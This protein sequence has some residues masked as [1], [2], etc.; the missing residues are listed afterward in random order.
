TG[1]TPVAHCQDAEEGSD[2]SCECQSPTGDPSCSLSWPGYT[3]GPILTMPNVT[4]QDNGKMVTCQMIC[5][6][7]AKPTT[8]THTFRVPYP[9]PSPPKVSGHT[10]PLH[11]GDTINC[12]V[13]GGKPPVSSVQLSCSNN[14]WPDQP[15]TIEGS[16][17]TSSLVF[18]NA[19]EGEVRCQCSAVWEQPELYNQI[20]EFNISVLPYP[21]VDPGEKDFAAIIGVAAA[22]AL[23][24]VAIVAAVCIWRKKKG[25][26]KLPCRRAGN[27]DSSAQDQGTV[28][29]GEGGV[30]HCRPSD[31]VGTPLLNGVGGQTEPHTDPTVPRPPPHRAPSLNRAADENPRIDDTAGEAS[32]PTVTRE[33]Q[34]SE[35]KPVQ[36][37]EGH[38]EY[39]PQ[40]GDRDAGN[41]RKGGQRR[42]LARSYGHTRL[43][44]QRFRGPEPKQDE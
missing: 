28:S 25:F 21:T 34:D 13:T 10:S 32:E 43:P 19:S 30:D 16:T 8:V 2:F 17:V 40:P 22:V 4:R 1:L 20:V 31:T 29:R 11:P 26:V 5:N 33:G 35:K 3:K 44:G 24:V 18:I 14:T 39:Q 41:R 15:D 12:T 7:M 23:A 27:Q 6:G 9:P 36:V 42:G 38:I 37:V